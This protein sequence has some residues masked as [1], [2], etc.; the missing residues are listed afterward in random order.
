M[1]VCLLSQV[2]VLLKWLHGMSPFLAKRLPSAYPKLYGKGIWM[3]SK[4]RVLASGT[5]SRTLNAAYFSVC[6]FRRSTSTVT[7]VVNLIRLITS[8]IYY[9]ECPLC[10]WPAYTYCRRARLVTVAVVC[11]LSSSVVCDTRICNVTHQWGSTRRASSVTS[12]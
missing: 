8:L 3:S 4:I 5:W 10:Y 2:G 9:T 11:H 6:L 1:S 7:S 12:R